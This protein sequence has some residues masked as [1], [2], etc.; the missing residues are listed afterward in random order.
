MWANGLQSQET[1]NPSLPILL[2]ELEQFFHWESQWTHLHTGS[3][4]AQVFQEFQVDQGILNDAQSPRTEVLFHKGWRTQIPPFPGE[5]RLPHL[6]TFARVLT[7]RMFSPSFLAHRN[8]IS[9]RSSFQK[10]LQEIFLQSQLSFAAWLFTPASE[11]MLVNRRSINGPAFWGC[12]GQWE[13]GICGQ[14]INAMG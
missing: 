9:S 10:F 11:A 7:P 2:C 14:L 12:S 4:S 3:H 8:S 1:P 6:P 13:L 5:A